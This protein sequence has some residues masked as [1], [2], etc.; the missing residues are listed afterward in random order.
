MPSIQKRYSIEKHQSNLQIIPFIHTSLNT[1]YV[2]HLLELR[3]QATVKLHFRNDKDIT[4][5]IL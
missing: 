3:K 2:L 4:L 1:T 5:T